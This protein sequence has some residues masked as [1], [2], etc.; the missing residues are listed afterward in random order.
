MAFLAA[1][2][3]SG[4]AGAGAA[5]A[6]AGTMSQIPQMLQDYQKYKSMMNSGSAGGSQPPPIPPPAQLQPMQAPGANVSQAGGLPASVMPLINQMV[7]AHLNQMG[8]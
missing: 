2:M 7:S 3:G 4:A 5:G 1:L 6:G 8:G